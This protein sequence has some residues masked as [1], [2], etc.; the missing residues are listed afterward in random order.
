MDEYAGCDY[1]FVSSDKGITIRANDSTRPDSDELFTWEELDHICHRIKKEEPPFKGHM[2]SDHIIQSKRNE[3][4]GDEQMGQKHNKKIRAFN[5][6][7]AHKEE[8][9]RLYTP[10]ELHDMCIDGVVTTEESPYYRYEDFNGKHLKVSCHPIKLVSSFHESGYKWVT[11]T[12]RTT[13]RSFE[14][15]E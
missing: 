2:N 4:K 11:T 3:Y 1:I 14:V 9:K 6:Q 12:D 13:L 10:Q 5:A 8:P 7:Y 15:D